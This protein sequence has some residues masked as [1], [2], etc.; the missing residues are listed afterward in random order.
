M[1]MKFGTRTELTKEDLGTTVTKLFV[2][3]TFVL[4]RIVPKQ[5]ISFYQNCRSRVKLIK[6]TFS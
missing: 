2:H 3:A 1:G 5:N 6:E 4:V